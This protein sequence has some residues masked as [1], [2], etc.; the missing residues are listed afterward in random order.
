MLKID[1]KNDTRVIKA[2]TQRIMDIP[3]GVTVSVASLGG[4]ELK[5]GTPIGAPDPTTGLCQVVKTVKVVTNATNTAVTIEV[6]KGHHYKVGDYVSSGVLVG[7]VITAIDKTTST[8]KD[9]ITVGTTLGGA[10]TAGDDLFLSS[11][12]SAAVLVT[13]VAIVGT[14]YD[15]TAG[16]TMAVD[17]WQIAQVRE[18][19]APPVTAAIK[20]ALKGIFY[21]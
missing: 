2:I 13:P 17:A 7:Q 6:E 14:T 15:V 1:R 21:L 11:T 20:T 12:G 8:L 10:L 18:S 5:E 3:G 9:T 4:T 16:E 19:I